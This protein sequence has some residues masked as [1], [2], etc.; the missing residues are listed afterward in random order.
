MPRFF[1]HLKS[2]G[3]YSEDGVG[4][5]FADVETAYLEAHHSALEISFE[6]LR[7][8][9]DPHGFQFDIVDEQGSLMLDLPFSEV[10]KPGPRPVRPSPILAEIRKSVERAKELQSEIRHEFAR[11]RVALETARATIKKS[12]SRV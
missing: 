10:L 12:R 9:R 11:T 4:D 2:P 3:N 5:E 6:M 1:F 8:R 7:D